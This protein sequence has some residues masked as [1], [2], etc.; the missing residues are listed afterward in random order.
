MFS[1]LFLFLAGASAAIENASHFT[2]LNTPEAMA[3]QQPL[4][5]PGWLTEFT[6]LTE[7]P[8]MDPPYIPLD[9]IDFSALPWDS[10]SWVHMQGDCNPEHHGYEVCSFD[11]WA[12]VMPED[13]VS[14]PVLSQTF[15]DGPSPFT[16]DLIDT[17]DVPVTFFT[18]GINVVRFPQIYR[19]T[20]DR[21]HLMAS[22]T[23]SHKFLPSLSNEEIVA[24]IEWSVWA[25]NATY[26]HIPK[27][28][29]PPYGGI[30]NRVRAILR[31]FGM[32]A[33]LWD[34]DSLDWALA[35]NQG[36]ETEEELQQRL[37]NFASDRDHKG[38]ILEHDSFER[39][40]QIGINL[41]DVVGDHQ[42]TVSKCM[43]G[44]DYI[45][46]F[47]DGADFYRLGSKLG[48]LGSKLARLGSRRSG[49]APRGSAGRGSCLTRF[50][51]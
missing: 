41:Y 31:H 13:V 46:H 1:L 9:F 32:Q 21:G 42:M 38:L 24:Q 25:M 4:P 14:C 37:R 6:G 2:P 23:W 7:W 8:G 33:V 36:P 40:V 35:S 51:W 39:T 11:C 12:C 15:D 48:K 47:E 30:D 20:A 45:Q 44:L 29:R 34:F 10:D 50:R 49:S 17:I 19:E 28:F 3:L 18:I 22:H 43:Q 16:L 26:G 5:V 27:W